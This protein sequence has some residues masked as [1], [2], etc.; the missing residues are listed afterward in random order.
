[1]SSSF[2]PQT[3][4]QTERVNQTLE[5]YLRHFV[6][7]KLNDWDLLLSRAEFAHNAAYHESIRRAPLE[8]ASGFA[9]RTPVGERAEVVN[10]ES[11]A[12]VDSLH[13]NLSLA[14]KL[15]IA[16]QQRQKALV[17][18]KRTERSFSVGDKVLLSTK[19]LRLKHSE[20]SRKLLPK[21]VGPFEVVQ[22]VG[23]VAYKL[24]MNPRW[25]IHPVFHVSLLEPYRTDGRVQP[26]PPPVELEGILEYEVAAIIDHRYQGTRNPK[27]FYLVAW[28]G[29]GP[30]HNS[31]EPEENLKNAPEV[32]A[33]YWSE[34]AR[35]QA[36]MSSACVVYH[37]SVWI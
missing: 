1:M 2:H 25:R 15:L 19:Y 3:D 8:L 29:Y 36:E 5:T 28:K 11:R 27:A 30:E 7:L 34:W 18:Q 35:Q 33:E 22:V 26:P 31:W 9:P 32:L 14:R 12:F 13:Q 23:P 17:D 24:N 10:P 4:G 37:P 21:Y 16:A 20:T 6:F